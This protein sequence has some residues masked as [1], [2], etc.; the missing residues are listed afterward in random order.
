MVYIVVIKTFYIKKLFF[1]R[2]LFLLLL[3]PFIFF[4][5]FIMRVVTIGVVAWCRGQ[6]HEDEQYEVANGYDA[7]Q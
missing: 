1:C 3:L 6:K 4:L 2:L 5:F 7:K